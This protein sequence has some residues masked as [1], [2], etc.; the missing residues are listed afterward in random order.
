MD[1]GQN[2]LKHLKG[3]DNTTKKKVITDVIADIKDGKVPADT[4]ACKGGSD[5]DVSLDDL[6]PDLYDKFRPNTHMTTGGFWMGI[7]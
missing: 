2:A 7:K 1:I 6:M 5:Y 3:S 4:W